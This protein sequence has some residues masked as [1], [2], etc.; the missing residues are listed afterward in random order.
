MSSV[1]EFNDVYR[2]FGEVDVLRGLTFQVEAGEIYA[3]LGRNGAGKT[4]ALRIL[5]GFLDPRHGRTVVL[6]TDSRALTPGDRGHRFTIPRKG[7]PA[8]VHIAGKPPD[9]APFSPEV[10]ILGTRSECV[11]LA[12]TLVPEK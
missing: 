12:V 4:T 10:E 11:L 1:I 2:H 6:G 8:G 5:L 9:D 3:L 7:G